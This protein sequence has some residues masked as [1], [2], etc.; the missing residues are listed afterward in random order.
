MDRDSSNFWSIK[1]EV[2]MLDMFE[3]DITDSVTVDKYIHIAGPDYVFH[4]VA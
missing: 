4:L 1:D 2:N 3:V